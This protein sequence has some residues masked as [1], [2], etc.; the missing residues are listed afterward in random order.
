MSDA[1]KLS[2]TGNVATFGGVSGCD[3]VA[4][5]EWLISG[6]ILTFTPIEPRDTCRRADVLIGHDFV[7]GV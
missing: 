3:V 5:Y 4:K 6:D 2:V 1:G 7:R